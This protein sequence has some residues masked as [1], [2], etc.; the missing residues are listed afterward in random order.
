[1]KSKITGGTSRE[2][3]IINQILYSMKQIEGVEKVK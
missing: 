3:A 1:M 2:E